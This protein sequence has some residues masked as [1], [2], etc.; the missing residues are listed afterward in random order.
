MLDSINYHEGHD[1]I[2]A[3]SWGG[4]SVLNVASAKSLDFDIE[5]Q[6]TGY[7]SPNSGNGQFEQGEFIIPRYANGERRGEPRGQYILREST[8]ADK[9]A[10]S[11]INRDGKIML[12]HVSGRYPTR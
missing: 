10:A 11:H 6:P 1:L 12:G 7:F 9:F 4:T 3:T 8:D 5:M 2:P